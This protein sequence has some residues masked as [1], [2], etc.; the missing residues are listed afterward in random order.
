V[1]RTGAPTVAVEDNS[2][3]TSRPQARLVG[4][5][6]PPRDAGQ[7]RKPEEH[8]KVLGTLDVLVIGVIEEVTIEDDGGGVVTGVVDIRDDDRVEGGEG[9]TTTVA[10]ELSKQPPLTQAY[11]G[12]Q[13]PPPG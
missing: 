1:G 3:Q 9:V 6:P 11:P 8:T 4:Q 13:Q 12:M 7:E 5:Q 10:V 2:G